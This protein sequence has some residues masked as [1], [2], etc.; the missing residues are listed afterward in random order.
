[1]G[2]KFMKNAD[3]T[4]EEEVMLVNLYY[5]LKEHNIKVSDAH[6]QIES[7][8]NLLKSYA[9]AQ[10]IQKE[11]SYRNVAGVTM[12]L[13]NIQYIDSCGKSGL[14]SASKMDKKVVWIYKNEH[15]KFERVLNKVKNEYFVFDDQ[16]SDLIK[17]EI[18]SEEKPVLSDKNIKKGEC[19]LVD[20]L[21]R[22]KKSSWD[23][24]DNEKNFSEFKKYMHVHRQ[25]EDDLKETIL[26]AKK[27]G[28][29]CLI[30]LCGN[31]GDGKSHLI[32]Y[33]KN[34]E[35]N[36]LDGF[37]IYND[38]TESYNSKRNEKEQ[39]AI[40][41]EKFSDD[42]LNEDD[43]T[44]VIVAINLGVLNNFID[45]EEGKKF[46]NLAKF[47]NDKKILIET[48]I[49]DNGKNNGPFYCVNFG[50]YHIYRLANGR[51]ESP[52]IKNMI[53]KIFSEIPENTF[54]SAYLKCND[55]ECCNVCP[56][57]CNFEM[58]QNEKVAEGVTNVILETVIKDKIILS[59]RDLLNLLYDIVVH[60]LFNKKDVLKSYN[61]NQCNFIAEYSLVNI[62]FDHDEI[63]NIISHIKNYDFTL[64][65]TEIFDELVTRFYNTED[66]LDMLKKYVAPSSVIEQLSKLNSDLISSNRNALFKLF[67]RLY[68][69]SP[70]NENQ[71]TVNPEFRDY[72]MYLY[73]AI[74]SDKPNLKN[75]Y[76]TVRDCVYFWNGSNDT[77]NLNLKSNNEQYTISTPLEISS[78]ASDYSTIKAETV[79]ERFPSSIIIK[80]CLKNDKSK[81]A[82]IP[83]DYDL[84]KM[85]TKVQKGY[86]PSAKDKN[87]YAG[88]VSF[89]KKVTSFSN[90][91]DEITIS[92]YEEDKKKKYILKFDE[93]DSYV[94]R[95]E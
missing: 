47:V 93:F 10:G 95:G 39:L 22:L 46:T 4:I 34:S 91:N 66:I 56:V 92:H 52:Y 45:S 18:I 81:T 21:K 37:I 62:M 84:Y 42:Q 79:F 74:K 30:L 49:A 28:S 14:S 1:M 35:E 43:N 9:E 25:V 65:R 57:R 67:A 33:L 76:N 53:G 78:D 51:V 40:D 44:K 87:L 38:A 17:K 72:I 24:V 36:P 11:D 19:P 89:I 32:S 2:E 8:S 68:K 70:S 75:L 83:I 15:H 12:K 6:E 69:I 71:E 94:F 85:L 54:Y 31:V 80:F 3:W 20:E 86:R 59:T 82:S 58:M 90:E 29:K 73:Y 23:A 16:E 61:K 55:C 5:E 63:S 41:L 26:A 88:F 60:P 50:D 77:Q 48:D 64:Q 27:N 7:L 13:Q